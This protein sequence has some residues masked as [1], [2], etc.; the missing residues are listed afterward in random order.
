MRFQFS[1][2]NFTVIEGDQATLE[3]VLSIPADRIVDVI[4]NTISTGKAR[5]T[6]QS[7]SLFTYLYEPLHSAFSDYTSVCSGLITIPAW[8]TVGNGTVNTTDDSISE[9]PEHFSVSLITST[10]MQTVMVDDQVEVDVII[11]DDDG[12]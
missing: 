8:S 6:I 11:F 9:L 10:M 2:T 5:G 3:V 1:K 7:S 4:F 12:N